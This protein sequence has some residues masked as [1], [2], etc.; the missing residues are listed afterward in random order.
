MAKLAA[1]VGEWKG[2][3]WTTLPSKGRVEFT[4]IEQ[5]GRKVGDTVL[6]AEGRSVTREESGEE[7]V[8]HDGL[9]LVFF[10]EKTGTYRWHGHDVGWGVSN[11]E[12]KLVDGGFEWSLA[13]PGVGATVRFTIHLD[14]RH[15][16]EVGEASVDGATW[17]KFMETNLDRVGDPPK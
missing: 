14:E 6:L 17:S 16:R 8:L 12:V 2:S 5:V 13:A 11:A 9:A 7:V 15:W 4:Q 10:D 3:G 1:W